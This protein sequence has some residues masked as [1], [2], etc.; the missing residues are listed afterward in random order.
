MN[1]S[2]VFIL[3]SDQFQEDVREGL[4]G[5]GNSGMCGK[6]CRRSFTGQ[7]EEKWKAHGDPIKTGS[8]PTS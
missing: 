8:R 1:S 5:V 4:E 7:C 3:F 2:V 6:G